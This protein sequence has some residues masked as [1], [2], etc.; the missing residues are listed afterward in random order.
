MFPRAAPDRLPAN[1]AALAR[2]PRPAALDPAAPR[3]WAPR[4]GALGRKRLEG[5]RRLPDQRLQVRGEPVVVARGDDE[6]PEREGLG[7]LL[8]E[9]ASR[10]AGG[11][12]L[13]AEPHVG[14]GRPDGGA[15]ALGY[16]V[17]AERPWPR[18]HEV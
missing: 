13:E 12:V 17:V 9:A 10:V 5:D 18:E 14:D 11:Q 1:P 2:R 3:S 6:V 4:R 8:G 7:A 16:L 15:D